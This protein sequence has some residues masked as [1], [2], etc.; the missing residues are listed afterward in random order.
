M[1]FKKGY[2]GLGLNELLSP[3]EH[4]FLNGGNADGPNYSFS[5]PEFYIPLCIQSGEKS[6]SETKRF[7]SIIQWSSTPRTLSIPLSIPHWLK[8]SLAV[9]LEP[10]NQS[11]VTIR[12]PQVLGICYGDIIRIIKLHRRDLNAEYR[13]LL[14][15]AEESEPRTKYYLRG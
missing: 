5:P 9:S 15:E 8:A 6:V 3:Q 4:L 13:R 12:D 7:R 10:L 1:E 14:I 2:K 11:G